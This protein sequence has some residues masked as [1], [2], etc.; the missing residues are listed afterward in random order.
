MDPR[1]EMSSG[2][3]G[4]GVRRAGERG[5]EGVDRVQCAVARENEHLRA[6]TYAVL[7]KQPHDLI[8][9]GVELCAMKK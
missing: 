8:I 6:G 9:S 2:P 1:A 7:H 4:V 5:E 3:P